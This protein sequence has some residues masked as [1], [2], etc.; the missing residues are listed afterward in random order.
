MVNLITG[1][2]GQPEQIDT[3]G[4]STKFI[5]LSVGG[6]DI[7][8]VSLA[9]AC[10]EAIIAQS[11]VLRLPGRSCAMQAS[12]SSAQLKKLR[13]R[14]TNLYDALLER[15]RHALLSVLN[16]PR[17]FPGSYS[18]TSVVDRQPFCILDDLTLPSSYASSL[19]ASLQR[20]LT[21]RVGMPVSDAM[22]LD[23]FEQRL[24]GTIAAAVARVSKRYR[25]RILVVDTYDASVANNCTGTTNG[26]SVNGLVLS[27]GAVLK[28][29]STTGWESRL[30]ALLSPASFHPTLAGQQMFARALQAAIVGRQKGRSFRR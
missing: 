7:G 25:S 8:F 24:N 3:V 15:S 1:P 18:S 6:D 26:V 16:Y 17:I 21:F 10:T 14:L 29:G 22:I 11:T 30:S 20:Q 9:K 2:H 19:P 23:R 28:V 13:I 4:P 27:P 5:S 12:R